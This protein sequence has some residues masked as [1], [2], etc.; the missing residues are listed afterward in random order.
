MN[1]E[2]AIILAPVAAETSAKAT[3][4]PTEERRGLGKVWELISTPLS[5]RRWN[6]LAFHLALA[7]AMNYAYGVFEKCQEPTQVWGGGRRLIVTL[8]AGVVDYKKHRCPHTTLPPLFLTI[9]SSFPSTF[10]S[11]LA[12]IY[13]QCDVLASNPPN[14]NYAPSSVP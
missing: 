4:V 10:L 1:L 12:L 6:L 3:S 7:A 8:A 2:A 9:F 5:P 13:N 11:V 14:F